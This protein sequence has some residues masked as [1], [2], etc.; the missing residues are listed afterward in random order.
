MND[1]S[2]D[3]LVLKMLSMQCELIECLGEQKQ[4]YMDPCMQQLLESLSR[5]CRQQP[6]PAAEYWGV[7]EAYQQFLLDYLSGLAVMQCHLP[8]MQDVLMH[9]Q[10]LQFYKQAAV[11]QDCEQHDSPQSEQPGRN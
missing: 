8:L 9:L 6:Q 2:Y 7:L 1:T 3:L 11:E 4:F 5:L 10:L